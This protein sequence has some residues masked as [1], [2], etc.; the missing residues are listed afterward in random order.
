MNFD[1]SIWEGVEAQPQFFSFGGN[2]LE[3]QI[4]DNVG[5][6]G[7]RGSGTGSGRGPRRVREF[8]EMKL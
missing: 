6:H 7:E 2:V 3:F 5:S 8:F 1:Q 4:Y